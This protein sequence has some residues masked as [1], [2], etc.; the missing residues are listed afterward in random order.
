MRKVARFVVDTH[1]HITSLY[2]P[3]TQEG[4][5][6]AE[7]EK[8]NGLSHEISCFDNSGLT[9]YDMDTY[10]VDMAILLPS[11]PGTT[12]DSQAKLVKKYP[13]KFRACCSDQ[14]TVLKAIRGEEKYSFKAGMKEVEDALKTGMFVGIGE[15]APGSSAHHRQ[16]EGYEGVVSF[17]Q[18]FE[19]WA[20]TCELAIKYDVPVIAH[21]QFIFTKEWTTF[22][23]LAKVA[24]AYP[25]AKIIQSHGCVEEECVRGLDAVREAYQ[26][27]GAHKN[28]YMETG[29][30][31]VEQFRVAFD[32][33]VTANQLMWGHDYGNVP[34]HI[35]TKRI[36]EYGPKVKELEYR[37]TFSMMCFN[38][39]GWPAVPTYQPDF[40][41]W[42]LRTI[43]RVGDFISQDEI[44]MIM[45]GTAAK[46]YKLPVPFPRMFPEGRPDI[47]GDK[48]A[49]SVPFLP[50]DQI[51]HPE[52]VKMVNAPC[53]MPAPNNAPVPEQD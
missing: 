19:E 8:W 1:C 27:I 5:E 45:G 49:E 30:W 20:E 29:G 44:N 9:L 18:R 12:N 11:I 41:G 23:M 35:V 3:G 14:A 50:N 48:A 17:E 53:N 39:E 38:Y 2:Q 16:L 21:D 47:F 31:G 46:L 42:G 15:F 28:I 13:N 32:S 43:D 52:D 4:W 7:E 34:Q 10:G 37:D 26:V 40:Y 25:E 36:Q 33:G 51:Q 6:L 22:D 24:Q